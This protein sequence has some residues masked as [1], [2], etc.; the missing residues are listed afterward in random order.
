MRM[1]ME[2]AE[3]RLPD[4]DNDSDDAGARRRPRRQSVVLWRAF[5]VAQHI[6]SPEG[7]EEEG[8]RWLFAEVGRDAGRG[9][10]K[11]RGKGGRRKGGLERRENKKVGRLEGWIGKAK[12]RKGRR[13][14][15][16]NWEGQ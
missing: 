3:R 16:L 13:V 1:E 8:R 4:D 12:A 2:I 6:H 7:G 15:R 5:Y 11:D 10:G 14:G 9:K